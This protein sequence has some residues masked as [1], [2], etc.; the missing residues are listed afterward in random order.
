MYLE[1]QPKKEIKQ[2]GSMKSGKTSDIKEY[3]SENEINNLSLDDL[4]ND[5]VWNAVRRSMTK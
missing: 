3:Y 4:D 5:E 1:K 2:M